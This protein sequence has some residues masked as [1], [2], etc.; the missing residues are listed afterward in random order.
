M[1]IVAVSAL[2][3]SLV[4]SLVEYSQPRY[5]YPMEWAYGVCAVLLPLLFV[6]SMQDTHAFGGVLASER[7]Q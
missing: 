3:A 1:F 7:H 6:R 4:V 2:G 5:S